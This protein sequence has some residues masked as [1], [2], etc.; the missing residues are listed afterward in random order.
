M[1]KTFID[2][3]IELAER[4]DSIYLLTADLGYGYLN[5][6]QQ[7]FPKRFYNVG[8]AEQNMVGIASGLAMCGKTVFIYSI[9]TFATMRCYEQI[10]NYISYKNLK[11]RIIGTGGRN[12]YPVLGISHN[13][14]NDEDLKIMGL[15]PNVEVICPASKDEVRAAVMNSA[16]KDHPIYIRIEK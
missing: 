6:F 11:V 1:R 7:L 5:R 16:T 2:S 3:L 15:L 9:L 8:V 13:C 4:D 10:R 14:P 12:C